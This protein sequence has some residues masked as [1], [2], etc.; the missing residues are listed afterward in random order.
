MT[1]NEVRRGNPPPLGKEG[2]AC[3]GMNTPKGSKHMKSVKFSHVALLVGLVVGLS[4]LWATAAPVGT[5]GDLI[6]GGWYAVSKGSAYI[7]STATSCDPCSGTLYRNCYEGDG[8]GNV[9]SGGGITVVVYSAA[10]AT[11]H[12]VG[13]IGVCSGPGYCTQVHNAT[14][15]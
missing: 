10:G 13:G 8:W 5:S 3:A 4:A 15:Y 6:T 9:C 1:D 11:P 7:G 14:C 12:A 2:I